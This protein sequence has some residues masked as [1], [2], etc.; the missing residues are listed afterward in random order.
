MAGLGG[1]GRL[2]RAE[3]ERLAEAYTGEW[4]VVEKVS[5]G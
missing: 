4:V 5:P 2:N 1:V 3:A